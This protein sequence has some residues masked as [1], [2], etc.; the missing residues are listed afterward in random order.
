MPSLSLTSLHSRVFRWESSPLEGSVLLVFAPQTYFCPWF[1][2]HLHSYSSFLSPFI[3]YGYLLAGPP[4]CKCSQEYE[5]VPSSLLLPPLPHSLPAWWLGSIMS[6]LSSPLT[7]SL[8][9]GSLAAQ[10]PVRYPLRISVPTGLIKHIPPSPTSSCPYA[11]VHMCTHTHTH[12]C[13]RQCMLMI[14]SA[15]Q[16]PSARAHSFSSYSC[17]PRTLPHSLNC[18]PSSPTSQS[19]MHRIEGRAD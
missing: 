13:P 19:L 18:S 10:A 7:G 4:A 1:L 14:C 12:L 16:A 17:L 8:C 6:S 11:C 15:S 5:S 2:S 3:S 9:E